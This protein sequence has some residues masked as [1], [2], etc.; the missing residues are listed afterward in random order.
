MSSNNTKEYPLYDLA[1]EYTDKI[2][3]AHYL[4]A[5]FA[6][7]HDLD[8][9][10]SLID[11]SNVLQ[12]YVSKYYVDASLNLKANIIDVS[13]QFA[14]KADK[15]LLNTK[16]NIASPIFTGIPQAPTPDKTNNTNQ[17]ATTAFVQNTISHL[18]GISEDT[19]NVL[20]EIDQY[21][22]D[23]NFV[24]PNSISIIESL[25]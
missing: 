6:T 4:L 19:L 3:T 8:S 22:R 23:L 11:L 1:F 9:Y 21:L 12:D 18:A 16:A 15:S 2:V 10:T 5:N 24:E 25:N 14:T 7:K 17:I 20:K 13:N